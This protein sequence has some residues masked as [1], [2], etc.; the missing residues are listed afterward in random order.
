MRANSSPMSSKRAEQRFAWRGAPGEALAV[1]E[2][3]SPQV[4]VSDIGMPAEDG[5]ALI[6]SVRT[7]PSESKRNVPAIALTAFTRNEDRTRALTEGFNVHIAKPV[8]PTALI[9]AVIDLAGQPAATNPLRPS[10]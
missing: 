10:T 6:R 3:Y 4:I 1:I 8:E 2:E 9:Q 7:L 5:Y